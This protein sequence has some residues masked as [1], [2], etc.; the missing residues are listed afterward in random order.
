MKK[1]GWQ[2]RKSRFMVNHQHT[3]TDSL[4]SVYFIFLNFLVSKGNGTERKA[5]VD[6][7]SAIA[8]K[9]QDWYNA[10]IDTT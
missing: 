8:M 10:S 7:C 1:F 9:T 6:D 5:F 2:D 4:F 3:I